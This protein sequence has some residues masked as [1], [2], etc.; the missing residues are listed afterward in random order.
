MTDWTEPEDVAIDEV[1]SP[2]KFNAQTVD[3]LKHLKENLG[4]Y[5]AYAERTSDFAVSTTS[6][7]DVTG[8]S[9]TFTADADVY[10]KITAF[11]RFSDVASGEIAPVKIT[12]GSNN[13][14]VSGV[15]DDG[16]TSKVT[17]LL[18]VVQPGAGSVT[19]K[20]R[21]AASAA[22][23]YNIAASATARPFLLVE[24]LGIPPS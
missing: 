6:D 11:L 8:L 1:A 21:A 23:A 4:G 15:G 10:Y 12:D 2:T 22:A 5:I 3:N 18:A 7:V 17:T 16:L 19:Y 20:V 24:R 13:T 9:V 14:Q